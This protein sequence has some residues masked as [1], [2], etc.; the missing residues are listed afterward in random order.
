M[1]ELA[2]PLRQGAHM[3]QILAAVSA[4]QFDKGSVPKM[5][6]I[7]LGKRTSSTK[8]ARQTCLPVLNAVSQASGRREQ[9]L[10]KLISARLMTVVSRQVTSAKVVSHIGSSSPFVANFV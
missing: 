9:S 6:K 3:L 7:R 1:Q 8:N 2:E 10:Q 4:V 5:S